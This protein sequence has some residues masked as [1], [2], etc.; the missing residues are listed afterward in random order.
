MESPIGV[1]TE[2]KRE[3]ESMSQGE[4]GSEKGGER[5]EEDAGGKE[6]K[7]VGEDMQRGRG[8]REGERSMAGRESEKDGKIWG[9]RMKSSAKGGVKESKRTVRT[10]KW[11]N[12]LFIA[13]YS[14]FGSTLTIGAVIG[15][16]MS[17]HIAEYMGRR[18][19]MGLSDIIC[20][21]GWLAIVFAKASS[22][23]TRTI[24]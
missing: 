16:I 20:I 12:T 17:G 7:E 24:W 6:I 11:K 4:R 21:I 3:R 15:A 19:A 5:E 10:P 9:N 13:Q 14:L 1:K 8:Q 2:R 18:G 22:S 23:A